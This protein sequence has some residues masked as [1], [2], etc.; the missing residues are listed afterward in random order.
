V[1]GVGERPKG[2]FDVIPALFVVQPALDE[3]GDE[4]TP[5]SGAD[6]SIQ[7]SDQF[8]LQ[9]YVHTHVLNIAHRLGRPPC[10]SITAAAAAAAFILDERT[11]ATAS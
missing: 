8:V 9:R 11:A 3:F 4:C 6:P 7:L 2:R 1:H 5:L 10:G